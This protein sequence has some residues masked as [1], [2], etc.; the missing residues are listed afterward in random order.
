MNVV[1][2]LVLLLFLP[3]STSTDKIITFRL[4]SSNNII[5][6]RDVL[7]SQASLHSN[8]NHVSSII[9][10]HSTMHVPQMTNTNPHTDPTITQNTQISH[11]GAHLVQ[12]RGDSFS[13]CVAA[14]HVTLQ[15]ARVLI[16]GHKG[17]IPR[18]G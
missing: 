3:L 7:K 11:L 10:H 4:H 14:E 1:Q 9:Y 16:A 6:E 18:A 17:K 8:P 12:G 2:I 13:W 5:M 15:H